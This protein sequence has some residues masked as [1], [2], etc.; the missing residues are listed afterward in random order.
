MME[1]GRKQRVILSE[2][3]DTVR[4]C[5]SSGDPGRAVGLVCV[6]FSWAT[7]PEILVNKL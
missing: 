2:N 4:M 1:L 3:T 5:H 6:S 7:T